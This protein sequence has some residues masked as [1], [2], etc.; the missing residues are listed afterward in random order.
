[1]DVPEPDQSPFT[2][3]SAHTSKLT[4]VSVCVSPRVAR[5]A[6]D[7]HSPSGVSGIPYRMPC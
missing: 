1:M 7:R 3:V 2:A 4:R 6:H 5:M